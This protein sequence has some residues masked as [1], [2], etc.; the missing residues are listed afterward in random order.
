MGTVEMNNNADSWFLVKGSRENGYDG[1]N[2]F[3][4]YIINNIVKNIAQ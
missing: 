2:S 3:Y 4:R 1:E